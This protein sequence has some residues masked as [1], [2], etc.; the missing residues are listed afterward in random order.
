M[1]KITRSKRSVGVENL[2]SNLKM[3]L[4]RSLNQ[5]ASA[6]KFNIKKELRSP[7]KS[8]AVKT[9]SRLRGG[10]PARRSAPGESLARDTGRSERLIDSSKIG[11]TLMRVGFRKDPAGFDYVSYQEEVNDRPTMELA[12]KKSLSTIQDIFEKNLTPR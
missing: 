8:G 1:I 12:I 4:S 11:S 5:S 6:V 3:G 7:N 2:S 9:R 10:S